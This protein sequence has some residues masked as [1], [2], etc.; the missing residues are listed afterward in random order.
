LRRDDVIRLA[1]KAGLANDMGGID[2]FVEVQEF[3]KLVADEERERCLKILLKLHKQSI[4]SHS[5]YLHAA[6][7]LDKE[8]ARL[9]DD[10]TDPSST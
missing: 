5:Y 4:H 3:A 10:D 9:E 1:R 8:L 7:E 2:G 6:V